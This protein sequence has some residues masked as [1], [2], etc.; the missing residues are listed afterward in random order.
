[1]TIKF[2]ELTEICNLLVS[3]LQFSSA[4]WSREK[5]TYIIKINEVISNPKKEEEKEKKKTSKKIS[6]RYSKI[7]NQFYYTFK[8]QSLVS[9]VI[10]LIEYYYNMSTV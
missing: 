8:I 1:M 9:Q 10:N 4:R 6:P 3:I 2:H 5:I 7:P